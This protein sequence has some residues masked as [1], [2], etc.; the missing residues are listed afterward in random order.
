MEQHEHIYTLRLTERQ[1][2]LL[3]YACDLIR[4]QL[5]LDR[6]DSEKSNSTVDASEAMQW[7]SEPLPEIESADATE[8]K[9]KATRIVDLP[10]SIRVLNCLKSADIETLYDLLRVSKTSLFKIKNFGKNS[11]AEINNYFKE[12]GYQWGTEFLEYRPSNEDPWK[13]K[14]Y[15]PKKEY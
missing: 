8:E 10:F 6:P 12:N 1:A 3:S 13:S 4:H 14:Y 11:L 7:G 15:L 9:L 5:W 2:K